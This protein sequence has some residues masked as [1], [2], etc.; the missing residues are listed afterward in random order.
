[1]YI[2]DDDAVVN[3]GHQVPTEVIGNVGLFYD[4]PTSEMAVTASVAEASIYSELESPTGEIPSLPVIYDR[5]DDSGRDVTSVTICEEPQID[6]VSTRSSSTSSDVEMSYSGLDPSTR[7]P[8]PVPNF[9]NTMPTHDYVN[10]SMEE[11]VSSEPKIYSSVH[12]D[13]RELSE[14]ETKL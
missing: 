14:V 7:E 13:A 11:T 2:V 4:E 1:M 6:C 9:Y 10:T 8:S 3:D 12:L 5:V